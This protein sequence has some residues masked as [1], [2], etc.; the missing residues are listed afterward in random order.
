MSLHLVV[1]APG[2]SGGTRSGAEQQPA[3]RPRARRSSSVTAP[4]FG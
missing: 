2:G 4:R 3:V 1:T